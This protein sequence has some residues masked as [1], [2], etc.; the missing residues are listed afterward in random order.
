MVVK[1]GFW[2]CFTMSP[3]SGR[4]V[5]LRFVLTV[6]RSITALCLAACAGVSLS[7]TI[8]FE[9]GVGYAQSASFE[10]TSGGRG[11]LSGPE[12]TL[13]QQ[14]LNVPFLGEARIGASA[15][16][17][18]ALAS[19]GDADGTIYRIFARG[20]TKSVGDRS[21]YAIGG[22][23][24]AFGS[25]RGGSFGE[26]NGLGLDFGFGM[27]LGIGTNLPGLPQSSLEFIMHQGSRAQTRGW[28]LGVNF[29][30]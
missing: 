10:K 22:A 15:F 8:P 5:R 13:S 20:K 3:S 18:G 21:F 24:L 2:V 19:G 14:L 1:G 12:F 7:Q 17:G 25:G 9:F 29:R 16:M 30:L 23:Y 27:P 28:S 4:K 11:T 26:V 6:M